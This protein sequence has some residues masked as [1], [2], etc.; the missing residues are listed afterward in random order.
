MEDEP[1]AICR[2]KRVAADNKDDTSARLPAVPKKKNGKRIALIGA[3]PASLT[4]ARD[5]AP[6]GYSIEMY[7]NQFAGGGRI[8]GCRPSRKA[9]CRAQ[10]PSK[11]GLRFSRKAS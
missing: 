2:L 10:R 4:V 5:L 8:S 3:G 7:D 1:V 9:R 11:R 6:L